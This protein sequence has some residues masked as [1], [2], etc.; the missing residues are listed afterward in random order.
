MRFRLDASA[1]VLVAILGDAASAAAQ[2][3]TPV[4]YGTIA[5][6]ITAADTGKPVRAA[7]VTFRPV[8][9][10]NATMP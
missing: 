6:T 3:K 8:A 5:G 1:V 7:R 4:K 2:A 10:G 9:G